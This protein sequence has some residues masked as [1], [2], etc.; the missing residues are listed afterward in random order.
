MGC[1]TS[2]VYVYSKSD[3]SA[4]VPGQQLFHQRQKSNATVMRS[5][6][7]MTVHRGTKIERDSS[8]QSQSRSFHGNTGAKIEEIYRNAIDAWKRQNAFLRNPPMT[9]EDFQSERSCE[10]FRIAGLV[11]VNK[12]WNMVG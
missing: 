3:V 8:S 1:E 2:V 9:I 4:S 10:Y 11:G 5:P 12:S 6:K 7:R